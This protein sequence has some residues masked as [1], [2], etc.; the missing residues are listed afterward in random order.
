MMHNRTMDSPRQL[1]RRAFLT[2]AGVAVIAAPTAALARR[3]SIGYGGPT[4]TRVPRGPNVY[5]RGR[6]GYGFPAL[7]AVA[8]GG[9]VIFAASL[10]IGGWRQSRRAPPQSKRWNR[11]RRFAGK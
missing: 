8:F 6:A 9:V 3:R 4:F 5:G 11:S 1:T 2:T 7:L 10:V